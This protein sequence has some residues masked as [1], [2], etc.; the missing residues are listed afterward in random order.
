M[1]HSI[2]ADKRERQN[3]KRNRRN[4]GNRNELRK[5]MKRIKSDIASGKADPKKTLS[6]GFSALDSAARKNAI[7]KKRAD[8]LKSRMA[9]AINRANAAAKK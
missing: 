8:R 6:E 4:R 1:G 5:D 3:L 7:P 9:L 2:S